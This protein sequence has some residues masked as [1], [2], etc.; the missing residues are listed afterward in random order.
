MAAPTVRPLAG[1][2]KELCVCC[3]AQLLDAL[4]PQRFLSEKRAGDDEGYWIVQIVVDRCEACAMSSLETMSRKCL[5]FIGHDTSTVA[6]V[7][8]TAKQH[9][10]AVTSTMVGAVANAPE[11][12]HNGNIQLANMR[13]NS[14]VGT[15]IGDDT[16]YKEAV[17]QI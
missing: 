6:D 8:L 13:G 12:V 16:L 14:I 2:T 17:F 7:C 3:H 4:T 9:A 11:R 1:N 10:E 15:D 5:E